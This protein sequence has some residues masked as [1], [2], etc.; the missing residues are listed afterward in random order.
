M[1]A[2]ANEVESLATR[3]FATAFVLDADRLNVLDDH[4]TAY[5]DEDH[6]A[7]DLERD[8]GSL[9]KLGGEII[10]LLALVAAR[11]AEL[12]QLVQE[13]PSDL[14]KE[15]ELLLAEHPAREWLLENRPTGYLAE[16][17]ILACKAIQSATPNAILEIAQKLDRLSSGGFTRGD[18]PQAL[19]C[20]IVMAGVGA[21]VLA[22]CA[23][24]GALIALPAAVVA[25]A[26]I[27]GSVAT[28]IAAI[29][30]WSCQPPLGPQPADA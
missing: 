10:E 16:N 20:A 19:K 5:L 24:P 27:G 14:D 26:G 15:L 29:K 12:R 6:D 8:Y 7:L 4:W 13:F 1:E 18:I 11:S 17:T 28:G 2:V 9:Q 23:G 21:G 3:S 30:G 25:G 22:A